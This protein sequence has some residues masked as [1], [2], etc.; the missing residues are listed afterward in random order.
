MQSH[1]EWSQ[2]TT[3]RCSRCRYSRDNEQRYEPVLADPSS[4]LHVQPGWQIG[5]K[6]TAMSSQLHLD[7]FVPCKP[8]AGQMAPIGLGEATRPFERAQSIS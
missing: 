8:I 3:P 1:Y 5:V 7:V 6:G 4:R 2:Q